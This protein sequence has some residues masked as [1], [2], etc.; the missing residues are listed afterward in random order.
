MSEKLHSA[1]VENGTYTKS[2][3]E[4]VSQFSTS[5]KQ[6]SL[7]KALSGAGDYTKSSKVFN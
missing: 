3:E 5:D 1:L 2:Y 7:Y 6:N 4:F